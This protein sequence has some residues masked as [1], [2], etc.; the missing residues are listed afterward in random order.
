[1]CDCFVRTVTIRL[2]GYRMHLGHQAATARDAGGEGR[3]AADGG[4]S[5]QP[6]QLR[7]PGLLPSAVAGPPEIGIRA[8]GTEPES[9]RAARDFTR[10][11]LQHWDMFA[12]F[13]DAAVVVSELVSNALCHGAR[14]GPGEPARGQVELTLWHRASHLVCAVT[15][16]STEPP[17]L[18]PPDPSA[19][20]GRGL[21][22]V[23]GLAVCWGWA[24]L[25]FHRKVVWAALRVPQVFPISLPRSRAPSLLGWHPPPGHGGPGHLVP[26]ARRSRARRSLAPSPWAPRSRGAKSRTTPVGREV[27]PTE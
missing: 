3:T 18:R 21:Q 8:I 6:G 2:R 14:V 24:M 9:P 20:A 17:V 15:D 7:P 10:A 5:R 27:Q 26:R 11:T 1:M 13:Q 23:Q 19:E 25:G 4:R 12:A 22:V 16:P